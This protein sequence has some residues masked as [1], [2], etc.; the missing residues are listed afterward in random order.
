MVVSVAEV[1]K[2][3]AKLYLKATGINKFEWVDKP[4]KANKDAKEAMEVT[5]KQF[6]SAKLEQAP[7]QSQQIEPGWVISV[8]EVVEVL[9][10]ESG[11]GGIKR[12]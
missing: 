11:F 7:R 8:D 9:P 5:L 3:M 4:E 2:P 10:G 1:P 12:T 6:Q